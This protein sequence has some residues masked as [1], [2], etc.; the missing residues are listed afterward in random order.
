MILLRAVSVI[1]NYSDGKLQKVEYYP[2]TLT[3]PK[4]I[5]ISDPYSDQKTIGLSPTNAPLEIPYTT[6]ILLIIIIAVAWY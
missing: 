2:A 1:F 6:I 5:L 3:T 4:L